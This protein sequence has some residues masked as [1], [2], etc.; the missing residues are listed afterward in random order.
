MGFDGLVWD[1]MPNGGFPSFFLWLLSQFFGLFPVFKVVDK[2]V[3][4]E[5]LSIELG[6]LVGDGS[7]VRPAF[8]P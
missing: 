1:S 7:E 8:A 5:S 4:C 3:T 6:K 2:S